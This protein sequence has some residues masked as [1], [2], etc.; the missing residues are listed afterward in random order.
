MAKNWQKEHK[1][2]WNAYLREYR[3][4][5]RAEDKEYA[6]KM[7]KQSRDAAQRAKDKRD[8]EIAALRTEIE[9]LKQQQN[10]N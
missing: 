10:N 1:E 8:N 7:R 4:K 5:R 6:E 2:E 3:K 9:T